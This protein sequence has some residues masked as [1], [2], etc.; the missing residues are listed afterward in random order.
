MNLDILKWIN[1]DNGLFFI[2]LRGI[3]IYF[4]AVF[5]IRFGNRRFHLDTPIDFILIIIL[6]S[7]L[8][9]AINGNSTLVAAIFCSTLLVVLHRILTIIT[10]QSHLIGKILKGVPRKLI[11]NGHSNLNLLK[12][13][14]ITQEDILEH[15][16]EK[17]NS[18]S[19]ENVKDVLLE[20]T[21]RITFVKK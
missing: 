2:C 16:R 1:T 17:L 12:E 15:C 7:V 4:F 10:F 19:L 20:R 21:G 11:D 8:A 13:A 3:I 18:N 14:A 5:L 6:G 9:R